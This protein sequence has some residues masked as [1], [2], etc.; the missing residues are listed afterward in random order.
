M[1]PQEF[2]KFDI[3]AW[4]KRRESQFPGIIDMKNKTHTGI[5]GDVYLLQGSLRCGRTYTTQF[6][7]KD[8]L[9]IEQ[10]LHDVEVGSGFAI[11]LFDEEIALDEAASEA[12]SEASKKELTLEDALN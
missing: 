4:W 11:S 6:K 5:F 1:R 8:E 2:A 7:F 12:R 9:D 3:L 10:E